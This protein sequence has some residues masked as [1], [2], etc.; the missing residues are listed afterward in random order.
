MIESF[1]V[2]Y[3]YIP[4]FVTLGLIDFKAT[5]IAGPPPPYTHTHTHTQKQ[6]NKKKQQHTK[7]TES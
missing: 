2:L 6:K 4:V 5:V 1:I 3:T 7:Q